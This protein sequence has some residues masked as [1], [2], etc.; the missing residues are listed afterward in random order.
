M[1]APPRFLDWSLAI[2]LSMNTPG[3]EKLN[4]YG[5]LVSPFRQKYQQFC[6]SLYK[7][8][9]SKQIREHSFMY[10]VRFLGR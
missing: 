9:E 8:V 2:I 10:D 4:T 7:E 1:G 6:L 3:F 5:S